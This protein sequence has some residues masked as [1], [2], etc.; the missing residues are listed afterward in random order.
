[1]ADD[2]TIYLHDIPLPEAWEAFTGALAAA[3]LWGPLAA[4]E[5]PVAEARGRVTAAPVW[6]RH[7]APHYHASAMDGYAVRARDTRGATETAPVLLQEGTPDSAERPAQAVNT[8]YPLP[9]WADAVIMIEHVQPLPDGALAIRSAVAPWQHV[10]P[11]GE[12]MVATELVLPANHVLRP[13]DL[14]AAAG[15]GHATLAV[16][17]RPRVAILATGSE[18]VAPG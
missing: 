1:M 10:R 12:D 18:L 4:E 14:G 3:G 2:R 13:V 7:S 17:R 11:L 8:G 9:V 15:C 6:A 5:V 16:R